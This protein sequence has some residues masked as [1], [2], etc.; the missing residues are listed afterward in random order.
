MNAWTDGDAK[1]V[2]T[3]DN[4]NCAPTVTAGDTYNASVYYE[5]SVPVFL[6]LYSRN[7]AGTWG[8]WTQ[9]PTFPAASTW[10]L[11]TFTTPAVPAGVNGASFGM[12]IASVGTV[13]TSDYSLVD[14]ERDRPGMTTSPTNQN[15]T[16]GTRRRLH[17]G[18]LGQSGAERPMGR[19]DRRGDHLE[20]HHRVRPSGTLTLPA[21][22]RPRAA[23]RTRPSSPTTWAR[24]RP[25][26]PP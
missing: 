18:R 16:A 25:V 14:I 15:V 24:S 2:T 3:F 26:R 12:T 5:S 9:T 8:Y 6:T 23:S 10:T 11:A 19:L 1:L 17:G 21:P 4:G 22:R 20:S 7:T 13:S